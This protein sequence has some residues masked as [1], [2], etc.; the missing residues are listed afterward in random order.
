MLGLHK[1]TEP[2]AHITRPVG[3]YSYSRAALGGFRIVEAGARVVEVV[4]RE[5][6]AASC[7]AHLNAGDARIEEHNL[8]GCRVVPA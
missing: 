2:M 3:T 5:S 4:S 1:H 8:I 6:V 7:C